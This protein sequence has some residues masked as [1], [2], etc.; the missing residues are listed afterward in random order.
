MTEAYK[1]DVNVVCSSLAL[2]GAR[3]LNDMYGTPAV[4]GLPWERLLAMNLKSLRESAVDGKSR[5]LGSADETTCIPPHLNTQ[6][7]PQFRDRAMG[8]T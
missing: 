2:D 5:L 7:L 4:L 6:S 1:A 8:G 3:I